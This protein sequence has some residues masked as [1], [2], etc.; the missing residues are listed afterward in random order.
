MIVTFIISSLVIE[1]VVFFT[2]AERCCPAGMYMSIIVYVVHLI[3]L[4]S[5]S[6]INLIVLDSTLLCGTL[7]YTEKVWEGAD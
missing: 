5:L 7:K 1:K 2:N 3:D 4:R 6:T